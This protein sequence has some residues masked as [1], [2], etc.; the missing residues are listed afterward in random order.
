M[1]EILLQ[2]KSLSKTFPGVKALNSVNF[3]VREGEVHALVGEN[4]AG[5]STLINIIAGNHKPDEGEILLFKK[6][7]KLRNYAMALRAGVS[8]VY[9]ER[10]LVANLSVAENIFADRQP[11]TKLNLINKKEMKRRAK[12][13]CQSI[14]LNIPPETIVGLLS[15]HEQ[16]MIEI[17]KALS[18]QSRLLILDEPTAAITVKE[19]RVLFKVIRKLRESG[20]GIVYIS[21]HLDEIFEIA[22]RVT[23][24][25]DGQYVD[26]QPIAALTVEDIIQMMVGR[27]LSEDAYIP[28][29]I[30]DTIF[31]A[32]NISSERFKGISFELKKSEILGFY[33]LCG[34]GRTEV[35]RSIIGRNSLEEGRIRIYGQDA[36][37][38]NT[39]AALKAGIGYLPEDRSAQGLFLDMSVSENI[40]AGNLEI[41]SQHQIIRDKLIRQESQKYCDLL[42]ITHSGLD[43]PIN[44]LS[45]GNQQKV[46]F[47]KWLLVNP[48]ILIIDEPTRGV[49]VGAKFEIYK[50][51]RE[52]AAA[53]MSL[54]VISSDLPEMLNISDRILVMHNGQIKGEFHREE[55]SEEKIMQCASGVIG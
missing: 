32:E 48:K 20:M 16:Q 43:A 36:K 22:D 25:K 46:V 38:K 29:Q 12:E 11:R 28:A 10:S 30:G 52:Q 13:L 54:I 9:Q 15:P 27:E 47:S 18:N 42:N 7:T 37:L 33:G 31:S 35:A 6:Q 2:V 5:K 8:V 19:T 41:I 39:S 49:D 1:N 55:A 40:V 26:T 14:G 53:G 24:L 17:A 34:A 21:H 23:V 50:I 45:G 51:I 44:Q 3:D 4:G